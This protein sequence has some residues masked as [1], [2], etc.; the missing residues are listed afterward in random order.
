MCTFLATARRTSRGASPLFASLTARTPKMQWR[1]SMG[2]RLMAERFGF[3]WPSSADRTNRL[4]LIGMTAGTAAATTED[5]IGDH[6]DATTTDV[7]MT[8][9]TMT[10][11]TIDV[12]T[13]T[14]TVVKDPVMIDGSTTDEGGMI[15]TGEKESARHRDVMLV[16]TDATETSARV[17]MKGVSD[18]RCVGIGD[19]HHGKTVRGHKSYAALCSRSV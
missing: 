19:H 3:R 2:T 18:H 8:D 16:T 9:V 6:R 12:V 7:T 10:G 11:V 14:T 5:T 13:G 1:H 4:L 17:G 15:T